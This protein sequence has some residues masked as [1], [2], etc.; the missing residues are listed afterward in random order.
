MEYTLIFFTIN[1]SVESGTYRNSL[2]VK[3][4][5]VITVQ[6]KIQKNLLYV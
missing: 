6:L 4:K 3:I 2:N 1:L 5:N